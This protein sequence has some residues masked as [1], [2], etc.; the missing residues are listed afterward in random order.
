MVVLHKD[1]TES[2]P[3]RQ[4][5]ANT[6]DVFEETKVGIIKFQLVLF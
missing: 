3:Q 4:L 2:F 5:S 6:V 1:A